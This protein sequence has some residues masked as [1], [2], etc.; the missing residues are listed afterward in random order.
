MA[1][2]K[3]EPIKIND[4]ELIPTIIGTYSNKQKSPI[5]LFIV[6]AL[7]IA[8]V[9]FL[10]DIKKYI[11]NR[12]EG[13]TTPTISAGNDDKPGNVPDPD[14]GKK[15]VKYD[16]NPDTVIE[17]KDYNINSINL[18]NNTLSFNMTNISSQILNTDN[19]YIELFDDNGT[20]LE[21][22]KLDGLSIEPGANKSITHSISSQPTK[23]L[24]TSITNKDMPSVSLEYSDKGE[25]KLTCSLNNSTYSYMFVNEMLQKVIYSY[26]ENSSVPTYF[27]DYSYYTSLNTK[28]VS[29]QGYIPSFVSLEGGFSFNLSVDLTLA[30]IEKNTDMNILNLNTKPNEVKFVL[31]AR[32]FKCE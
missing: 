31:E 20:F 24:I 32:G 29:E 3:V 4:A 19:L 9:F 28:Y 27:N 18:S 16:I 13:N 5:G 15:I 26:N 8:S 7:L 25:A 30:D 14:E 11:E 1:K 6:L 12:T 22:I 10:P 17:E 21:R 23:L 2:K